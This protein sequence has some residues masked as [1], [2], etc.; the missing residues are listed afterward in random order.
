M[1]KVFCFYILC[2]LV[3]YLAT[4]DQVNAMLLLII[5]E[6]VQTA[7]TNWLTTQILVTIHNCANDISHRNRI[8][9][10]RHTLLKLRVVIPSH[11]CELIHQHILQ[12]RIL[13]LR[14]LVFGIIQLL[15]PLGRHKILHRK[16]IH[17]R[18]TISDRV[19]R[20]TI[21]HRPGQRIT[22][23]ELVALHRCLLFGL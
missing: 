15:Q 9:L 10:H 19:Q 11:H 8:E 23:G 4:K 12:I 1:L 5:I 7:Y 21:K 6:R 13:T 16:I 14:H 3:L 22:I 18:L 17:R 20:L 2:F